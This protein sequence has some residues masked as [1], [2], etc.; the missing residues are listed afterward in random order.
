VLGVIGGSGFYQLPKEWQPKRVAVTTRFG[1]PSDDLTFALPKQAKDE[2][3]GLCF[4]A[5]HGS[6]HHIPPH[7]INYR[8][9]IQALYDAGVNRIVAF[10][11][12]GSCHAGIPTG[13]LHLPDQIIDYSYGREHS[14]FNADKEPCTHIDFSEPFSAPLRQAIANA[15]SAK[16]AVVQTSGTYGCTQGPRLETAAEIRRMHGDGCDIVGMT[17]MPEAAL[18]RERELEYAALCAV[19][20]QGAGI[21]AGSIDR[22]YIDAVLQLASDK[23]L[24]IIPLLVS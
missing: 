17:L 22:Q 20:N 21:E 15:L 9:N 18:A 19:V 11:S 23:L 4:L 13:S 8:A 14:F 5:R 7:K 3:Y 12:V 24:A 16:E 2:Q 1:Q 10:N 6:N